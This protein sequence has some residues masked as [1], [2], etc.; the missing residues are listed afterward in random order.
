MTGQILT[1]IVCYQNP[2]D[3]LT[4]S[5]ATAVGQILTS[6]VCYQNHGKFL[7]SYTTAKILKFCIF[8]RVKTYS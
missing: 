3:F 6:I 1:S 7:T 8:G 4:S 2:R 5:Y